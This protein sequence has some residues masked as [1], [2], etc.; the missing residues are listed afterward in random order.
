MSEPIPAAEYILW[1]YRLLLGRDPEDLSVVHSWP[2]TD[3]Q[4]IVARFL[5]SAEFQEKHEALGSWGNGRR[6]WFIS[7]LENGA[8][9]WVRGDDRFVSRGVAGGSYRPAETA[10]VRRQVRRGMNVLD[11]GA[12]IGWFTVNMAMLAGPGGRV[13]A[14]EPREDVARYLRRTL[15]ENKLDNVVVHRCALA[16][17]NG[18]G[19]IALDEQDLAPGATHLVT[20]DEPPPGTTTQQ[21]ALRRL[22]SIVWGGV[23]FIKI[24]VEGAEK[25]VFDGAEIILSRDR[26]LILCDINETLLQRTSQISVADYL[27]YFADIDYEIRNL[28]PTGRCGERVSYDDIAADGSLGVACVPA[29][30]AADILLR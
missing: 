14:F 9:F 2:E 25:L 11:I 19:A 3:R 21:V 17:A 12:N 29:E 22:D 13:D 26:P 16:A 7:E 10:F 28:S 24:A 15:A 30:K 18:N 20:G 5:A 23:D 1:A 8:R 27:A 6:A 4:E